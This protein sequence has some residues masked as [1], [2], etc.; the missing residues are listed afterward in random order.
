MTHTHTPPPSLGF[1]VKPAG[2]GIGEPRPG[3]LQREGGIKW[4]KMPKKKEK[5]KKKPKNV[6]FGT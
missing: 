1:G 4:P 2:F 6:G 3:C 5:N